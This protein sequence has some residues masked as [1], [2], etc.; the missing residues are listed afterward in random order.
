MYNQPIKPVKLPIKKFRGEGNINHKGNQLVCEIYPIQMGR[1]RIFGCL[2]YYPVNFQ[3][4]YLRVKVDIIHMC[5]FEFS[6]QIC[7]S[8]LQG[9]RGSEGMGSRVPWNSSFHSLSCYNLK[10]QPHLLFWAHCSTF[11]QYFG[12]SFG[13]LSARHATV[14]A[15]EVEKWMASRVDKVQHHRCMEVQDYGTFIFQTFL[16]TP[17]KQR[18]KVIASIS[19]SNPWVPTFFSF[20]LSRTDFREDGYL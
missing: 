12:S 8:S 3:L 1:G 20:F 17:T 13:Q 7:M 10:F 14:R 6:S 15:C 18:Y 11:F 4:S 2:R 9:K 16:Q 19:T 5:I